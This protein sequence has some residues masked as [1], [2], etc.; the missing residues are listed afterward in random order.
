MRFLI[1][2]ILLIAASCSTND[3]T[4]AQTDTLIIGVPTDATMMYPYGTRDVPSLRIMANI[5]DRLVDMNEDGSIRP[6]LATSWEFVTPTVLR[7]NIRDN[8]QFH[9]G[10]TLTVEDVAFSVNNML[11]SPTLAQIVSPI[12]E[13][14]IIDNNTVDIILKAPFAPILAHLSQA[15]ASI[16]NQRAVEEAGDS[17]NRIPVGTGPYQFV[18]WESG[19]NLQVT[20]FDN[21]WGENAHIENIVFQVIVEDAS[22]M[23][24]LETGDVDMILDLPPVDIDRIGSN[25]AYF[26]S[27]EVFNGTEHLGLNTSSGSVWSDRRVR[28]AIAH[29]IDHNGIIDSVLFGAAES[30]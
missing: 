22:R 17:V 23:I 1:L 26:V 30:C 8:V 24:A 14:A 21:H 28:Q 13:I 25:P 18:S 11:A 2:S 12:Q 27:A 3:N 6:A 29:A 5:F 9:N 4:T 20:R 16:V 7:M 10:E 15:N 19:N